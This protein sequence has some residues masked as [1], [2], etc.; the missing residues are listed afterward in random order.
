LHKYDGVFVDAIVGRGEESEPHRPRH[1][2]QAAQ[3]QKS[4]RCG[5]H[6]NA[7]LT[8][9][10]RML[11]YLSDNDRRDACSTNTASEAA[12]IHGNSVPQQYATVFMKPTTWGLMSPES[13]RIRFLSART[14]RPVVPD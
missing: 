9:T 2:R 11:A 13:N 12:V 14:T 7:V 1:S 10:L 8:G 3:L 4:E 5:S 6:L